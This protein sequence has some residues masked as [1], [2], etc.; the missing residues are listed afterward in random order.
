MKGL[1]YACKDCH[2]LHVRWT[3]RCRVC[4]AFN[5][6]HLPVPIVTD[7]PPPRPRGPLPD[8][9]STIPP[10][11]GPWT[12][13]TPYAP[14]APQGPRRIGDIAYVPT[15]RI[16]TGS[17]GLD[18]VFGGGGVIEGS[19]NAVGGDPGAGKSTILLQ[20]LAHVARVSGRP[21]LYLTAEEN[22]QKIQARA[23]TLGVGEEIYVHREKELEQAIVIIAQMRP[24]M[25]VADSL[26]TFRDENGSI[27]TPQA[28]MNVANRF[29]EVTKLCAT[30][31]FLISQV[32]KSGDFAGMRGLEHLV[33]GTFMFEKGHGPYRIMSTVKNRDGSDYNPATFR[34][35]GP[36]F[37]ERPYRGVVEATTEE[38]QAHVRL[39]E[40]ALALQEERQAREREEAERLASEEAGKEERAKAAKERAEKRGGVRAQSGGKGN[41]DR[42]R[43]PSK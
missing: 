11:R 2:A 5:T 38:E 8:P 17:P 15:P 27:G 21:C 12:P 1:G 13:E 4:G 25:L 7:D 22:E 16:P 42:S 34:M 35:T 29:E 19:L 33:D 10:Q 6:L 30:T 40:K 37:E 18:R 43:A 36:P 3:G 24:Y 41:R 28:V 26:Q 23:R 32:N 9:R 31:G 39:E 20:M 14:R